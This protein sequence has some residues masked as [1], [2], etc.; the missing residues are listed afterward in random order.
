MVVSLRTILTRFTAVTALVPAAALGLQAPS[1][2]A[3]A[4]S[5]ST[6]AG[7]WRPPVDSRWQYQ[8][9]GSKTYASTGGVNVDIC[10]VPQ[11]GGACVRPSVFDIDLYA[12]AEVA[13]NN[14][15]LNT[16]AV[17]A[18]HAKGA[19]AICYV[20]AG[21]IEDFRPDYQEFVDWHNAHGK[22]LLGKPFSDE[23]PNERWANINNDKGQRDFLL[24]MMAA[25]V[26]KCAQAGFDG[27]EFDV[28]NAHEEGKSVTGWTVSPATQ[29]TFNKALAAIAHGKGLSVALKNDLSQAEELVSSFDY[30]V[31]E[32]CFQFDECSE[33][34]VFVKAGKPVF[35]VEYATA[36]SSFCA[37]SKTLK[38]N[39]LKKPEDYSLFDKPYAPCR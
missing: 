14:T 10:G 36:P 27:V 26:D 6:T 19:K 28:V 38:F 16:A 35:H 23:F 1:Q 17:K 32:E 7:I 33:L 37:K 11:S 13:G 20:D 15:T 30:A 12:A 18:I 9:Q 22:S 24:K 21:S 2:A 29:L 4:T 39:S 25:R 8:L 34:S 31:N 3:T 5:P